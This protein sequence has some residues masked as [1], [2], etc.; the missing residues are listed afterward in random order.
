MYSDDVDSNL[1]NYI[2][3]NLPG[4]ENADVGP[5]KTM[6]QSPL[7]NYQKWMVISWGMPRIRKEEIIKF[8]FIGDN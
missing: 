1:A 2:H 4:T 3:V 6:K 5:N 7:S 8:V